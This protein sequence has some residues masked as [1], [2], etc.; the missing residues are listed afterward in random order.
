[1]MKLCM[2]TLSVFLLRTRPPYKSAS[3]GPVIMRTRADEVS[4]QAVSPESI[5]AASSAN[6]GAARPRIPA[7]A[8]N[9][10]AHH[11]SVALHDRLMI[12]MLV[13]LLATRVEQQP[14]CHGR[15]LG[16]KT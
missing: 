13:P 5:L 11:G 10:P 12:A 7:A 15:G 14:W 3:P 2:R 4:I 16:G 6:A 8:M 1:M 9:S